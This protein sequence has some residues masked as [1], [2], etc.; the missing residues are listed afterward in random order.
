MFKVCVQ[1]SSF[2]ELKQQ[3]EPMFKMM[4]KFSQPAPTTPADLGYE[5]DEESTPE[6]EMPKPVAIAPVAA[7]VAASPSTDN[8]DDDVGTSAGGASPDRDSRGIP[9]DNRIHSSN[10]GMKKDGTWKYRRNVDDAMIKQI[11]AGLT[12]PVVA[13]PIPEVPNMPPAVTT[14]ALPPALPPVTAPVVAP[15]APVAPPPPVTAAPKAPAHSLITFRSNFVTILNDLINQGKIDQT[16][17]ASVT[18]HYKLGG[19]WELTKY[20]QYLTEVF[21][22]FVGWGFIQDVR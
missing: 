12:A 1:A 11:E 16:W 5:D 15:V 9:W 20:D 7:P 8:D 17:I 19:I 22:S 10:R 14:P 18:N 2:E 3:L 21:E 6:P 13:V 4:D